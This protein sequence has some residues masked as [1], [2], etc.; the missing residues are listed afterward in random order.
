LAGRAEV[1]VASGPGALVVELRA[2]EDETQ[3]VVVV[4]LEDLDDKQVDEVELQFGEGSAEQKVGRGHDQ[5][6]CV[7]ELEGDR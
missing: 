7:D 1:E 5:H 3:V 6:A 4:E 2:A